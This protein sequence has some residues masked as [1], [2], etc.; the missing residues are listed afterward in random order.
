MSCGKDLQYYP[1]RLGVALGSSELLNKPRVEAILTRVDDLQRSGKQAEAFELAEHALALT[2]ISDSAELKAVVLTTL[3]L[4]SFGRRGLGDT[5]QYF[6]NLVA[7]GNVI[8]DPENLV[9][10]HRARAAYFEDANDQQGAEL[11]Y[12]AAIE[13]ALTP[14]NADSCRMLLCV[15]RS[16]FVH[17]LC[18]NGRAADAQE[19]VQLAETYA[20]A[21]CKD[22]GGAVF[23][24][25]FNAGLH[26]ATT[27]RNEDA[28]LMRIR[29][30]EATAR[31]GAL[32][33]TVAGELINAANHLSHNDCHR[34]ALAAAETA[35]ELAKRV[36]REERRAFI[37]GVLYTIAAINFAAGHLEEAL[38][39]ARSLLNAGVADETAQIQFAAAQLI[40]VISRRIGDIATAVSNAELA[41]ELALEIDS[42]VFAKMNLAES[43]AD[44][45]KIERAL[46]VVQEAYYLI[47]GRTTVSER[48]R[49]E[50][51]GHAAVYA[52]QL[53]NANML[54]WAVARMNALNEMDE[55]LVTERTRYL[56]LAEGNQTIRRRLIDISLIGQNLKVKQEA[57]NMVKEFPR[58]LQVSNVVDLPPNADFIGAREANAMTIA[59]LL[60]WWEDTSNDLDAAS[61]DYDYWARGCF[62]QV[63]RNLQAFPHSLNVTVEVR[64]VHD[65]REAVRLWALYAEFILLIWKGPTKSGRVLHTVDGQWFGPWG[66]GYTLALGTKILTS[67][68]RPRYPA[69]GYA[70][71][72]PGDAMTLLLNEIKPFLATGRLLLVPASTVGCVSPGHGVMEQLLT[73]AANCI[74]AIRERLDPQFPIGL[75]PY[76]RD[77]P[78]EI[79]FDFVSEYEEDLLQMRTLVLRKASHLR[80][81]GLEPAP[82]V[83]ELEIANVLKRLRAENASLS[84]KRQLSPGEEGTSL[85]IAP[86]TVGGQRLVESGERAFSPLLALDS[87][88][89]GW[90]IG[91]S[92]PR[93][94][95]PRYRPAED[96]AFGT[97]LAPPRPGM[98]IA[99]VKK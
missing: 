22:K 40:S 59:P 30:L 24:M 96:E 47:D 13:V 60:K 86:F 9:M 72:L 50:A 29:T 12:L 52:S 95:Q 45:G 49:L 66:D 91:S 32:A 1:H 15:A 2:E 46:Q 10:F 48:L 18:N 98:L 73:E 88:G 84:A 56:A 61:L 97:W 6:H 8:T 75:L 87:I 17:Y 78:M 31:N 7:L 70:S 11:A 68:G 85:R 38:Q 53:G 19:H 35:L 33:R 27:I 80:L 65:V 4:M 82:K 57:V 25:A 81:H 77:I 76:A 42:A 20:T 43:L 64:T 99:T 16:E 89:Y 3:C 71:W 14:A 28:A 26:W 5:E 93:P 63:L 92:A 39:R 41:T 62:A 37:P 79:L 51:A 44:H 83:L 36:T 58:F 90:K 74:P 54:D 23:R 55:R 21:H 94:P 69:F 34:A 67:T